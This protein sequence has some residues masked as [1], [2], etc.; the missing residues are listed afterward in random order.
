MRQH[1]RL[2][3][4]AA[5]ALCAVGLAA[6]GLSGSKPAV[7]PAAFTATGREAA[8]AGAVPLPHGTIDIN[9]GDLY[10]LTELPRVGEVIGQAIIDNREA[11]GP[12]RY[13]EDLLSVRGIGEKTLEGFRDMLDL[14]AP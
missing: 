10:E 7:Q 11:Y 3:L 9:S 14:S 6:A 1:L 2:A 4:C 8:P 5:L 12:F 13:P